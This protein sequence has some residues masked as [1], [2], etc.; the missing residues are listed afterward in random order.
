MSDLLSIGASG[1]RAYQTALSTVSENIANVGTA[2]YV[3]RTTDM[4]EVI[5]T[6]SGKLGNRELST[7]GVVVAGIGRQA[8]A[9]RSQAVRDS[10]ADLAR[11]ATGAAALTK[12]QSA[13]TDDKLGDRIT[14]FFNAATTLAADPTSV[15]ARAVLLEKAGSAATAFRQT[16]QAL[17]RAT[18]ELDATAQQSVATLN[19]L[20]T[21]LAK[22]NDGLARS[23]PGSSQA[24]QLMDQRDQLTERMSAIAD[25]DVQTDGLG[26][27]QVR[28]GGAGGPVFVKGAGTGTVTLSRN[29][30]GTVALSVEDDSGS[31]T[32][33]PNGGS[34]AGVTESAQRLADATASLDVLAKEFAAG[35]NAVQTGGADLD[36]KAGAA[37]FASTTTAAGMTVTLTDPRGIAAAAAGSAAGSRDATNLAALQT[38]RTGGGYEAGLTRLVT[39]NAAALEQKNLVA[40][41]QTA[42]RDN[43]ATAQ[44][45]ASGVNLDTEAVDLLRFQQAY[46]ASSRVIQTARE[47]FQTIL[48]IR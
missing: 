35:V 21:A 48:D 43:A 15:P 46:Q 40:D 25:V 27:A 9:Y 10:S 31:H 14:D 17:A 22:V 4:R 24:A 11:T 32:L 34:L 8:D 38:A 39:D 19:S 45:S 7:N 13:L 41:A 16:G 23:Q 42:I 6:S 5:A 18:T 47:T 33:T 20:G 3:R 28:L 1:V 36:G 44:S 37:M 2:G 12:I 30:E 29:D 26:R